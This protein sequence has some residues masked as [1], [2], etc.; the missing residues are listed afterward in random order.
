M[1]IIK[2]KIFKGFYSCVSLALHLKWLE[3]GERE[4]REPTI[5][6]HFLSK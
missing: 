3:Y 4:V 6:V 5:P 1:N 2:K